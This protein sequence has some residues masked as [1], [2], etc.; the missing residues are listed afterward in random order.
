M[1]KKD[2]VTL[3]MSVVGG[4]LFALGMCMALLPEWNAMTQGVVIGAVGLVVLLVM[5]LVRR[6]MDGKPAIVFS[7]KAIATTLFGIFSTVVFGIGMCMTMVWNMMIPGIAVG[8]V[9]IILLLCLIP[10]CKGLK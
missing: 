7:G 3:M 8:I 5:L 10:V 9:G 2:F 4:I 6:K 1:K